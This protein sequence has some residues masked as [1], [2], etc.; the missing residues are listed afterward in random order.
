MHV[1]HIAMRTRDLESLRR[2]YSDV[3][4]LGELSRQYT[5]DG[6]LRSIWLSAGG[7]VVMLEVA[8]ER[9]PLP[10]L[11]GMDL[12]AFAIDA[13]DRAAFEHRLE[14]ACVPVEGATDHTLYV[15]DPEGRRI[16]LSTYRF[17]R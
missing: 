16:G 8:G 1:H 13:Q 15:R 9:E 17:E 7:A 14:V 2:F 5:P 4:G 3:L 6:A 11:G 10:T 12:L